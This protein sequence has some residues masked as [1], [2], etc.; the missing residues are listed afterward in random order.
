MPW[1]PTCH[2]EYRPGFDKCS[3]CHIELVEER[4]EGAGIPVPSSSAL[5]AELGVRRWMLLSVLFML[6][7]NALEMQLRRG[8]IQLATWFAENFGLFLRVLDPF[9][10]PM[11]FVFPILLNLIF[12]CGAFFIVRKRSPLRYLTLRNT[13]IMVAISVGGIM[14]RRLLNLLWLFILYGGDPARNPDLIFNMR[15]ISLGVVYALAVV[16]IL[17]TVLPFALIYY[18]TIGGLPLKKLLLSK[19]AI[20]ALII[21]V[22]LLA[23]FPIYSAYFFDGYTITLPALL[24]MDYTRP[25]FMLHLLWAGLLFKEPQPKPEDDEPQE[26]P[27]AP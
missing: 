14:V 25:L 3:D 22:L 23:V 26:E 4:P 2:I 18:F 16:Q 19:T 6:A 5:F 12:F 9:S 1:C 17:L 7:F 10:P 11:S 20:G 13:G 8:L 15:E 24:H 21:S 27:A